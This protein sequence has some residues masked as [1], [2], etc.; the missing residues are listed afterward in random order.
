VVLWQPSTGRA[1]IT[2]VNRRIARDTPLIAG[3]TVENTPL[4]APPLVEAKLAQP[5]IRAGVVARKRLFAVL[6]RLGDLELTVVSGPAGSGKTVLVSSWLSDRADL[7]PAWVTLDPGD[8]DPVRLW[9]HVAHAVD[10]I[11]NGIARPALLWLRTPRPHIH[12]AI[13][14]LL[15]GLSGYDGRV[16][17]V[18][19]DLHHVRSERSLR[20]LVY[21]TERLPRL[22]RIVATT[23]SDPGRRLGRLRAR[24]GLGELRAKDLAFTA[25]ET[26][27][28]LQ[29]AGIPLGVEEVELLVGRT[30]GWPAGL[31]LAALWLAGAEAPRDGIREFSADNRHV[32][33]YL[34]SE[35]LDGLD[36][37]TR[38]FL[39]GTSIFDRFTAKLCDAVLGID[40]SGRILADLERSNLFLIALD[41]RGAWYRY[42]HL[43]R[44]LLRIE[45]QNTRPQVTHELN[46]RAAEWFLASGLVEEGLEHTA[47]LGD[48]AELTRILTTE[49]AR[50]MRGATIDVFVTWV[51]RLSEAPL[52][53]NPIL[54][55]AG[56]LA[57]GM[58][59]RPPSARRRLASLAEM[60]LHL[61][62]EREQLYIR[63]L[64]ELTRA[65]LLDGD[66]GS[67]LEHATRATE[68]AR[69]YVGE[70]AVP[71]LAILAYVHYL[72][73]DDALAR[74]VAQ[75]AVD[76]PDSAQ[77]PHGLVHA[78]ALLAV[79][80]CETGH[81]RAAEAQA[82]RATTKA[83][84]LGL[85]DVWSSALA[86]HALGQALLALGEAQDA[87]RQLERA[88]MLRRAPEPRLDH[89]H[90]LLA[91]SRARIARGR[92]TL[93]AAELD[94][95]REQ[96]DA[97]AD[98][99]R[100]GPLAAEVQHELDAAGTGGEKVVEQPSLA[101]LAVLRLLAT[102]LSQREIGDEL[103]VS[104]NTVKTHTRRIYAKLGVNSRQA[105]VRQANT[106]GLIETDD[107]PG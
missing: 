11:R 37:D 79:L 8:D 90:T 80:E 105:A 44:E 74:T 64:V 106:L 30:E 87:E 104:I 86:H 5:R 54:A 47:A 91:L 102:D 9:T 99:G 98:I 29:G 55:A 56:A 49:H 14:E 45:L 18:V 77:R 67:S 63:T 95:A 32:T 17:I 19:D 43:F 24:G 89:A 16:V 4:A 107:S 70:L 46:R 58:V 75:E 1:G 61:V 33:D 21:A 62:G 73:G 78:E 2:Q 50:L 100:L 23:R 31:S 72:R 68:L 6:D 84:E 48:D 26:R 85:S 96:L 83:D 69:D 51:E 13:D 34:T 97:F 12:N 88:E 82:R 71:A 76:R 41:S 57:A 42:H 27:E 103:F 39:L 15:N 3:Q 35:V 38:R 53:R 93:A 40:N 25:P 36:E 52:E 20:S 10:R 65:G 66:L 59:A 28:L 92:L 60:N 81:P 94:S 101:E 7:T 22:A